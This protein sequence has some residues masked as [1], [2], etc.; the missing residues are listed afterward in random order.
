MVVTLRFFFWF[1][2][3]IAGVGGWFL[4]FLLALIANVWMIYDGK[5][6]MLKATG[7]LMATLLSSS[8]I[9]PAF[10]YRLT[11]SLLT[12]ASPN[13]LVSYMEAI[14]YLGIIAGITPWVITAGYYVTFQ[15]LVGCIRGHVYDVGLHQCPECVRI[16]TPVAFPPPISLQPHQ[17]VTDYKSVPS[18]KNIS[19]AQAWLVNSEGNSYQ[20]SLGETS[21]GRSRQN[22]IQ[23]SGDTTVGRHHAKVIEQNGHFKLIDL[24]TKN[25]TRVNGHIVRQPTMLEPNDEIC[26]GDDSVMRFVN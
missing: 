20:L 6:R 15:G 3:G 26:F 5:K 19:K 11:V 14:F 1:F 13:P 10:L 12:S 21:I 7:W 2:N 9:I 16:N 18:A 4:F 17:Q 8:L 25:Y 23:I 24:D 22:D